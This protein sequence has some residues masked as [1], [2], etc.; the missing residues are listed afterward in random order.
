MWN[1]VQLQMLIDERKKNNADFHEM[2]A[3]QKTLFWNSVATII[4]FEY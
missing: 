4:N 2:S 3:S 1:T